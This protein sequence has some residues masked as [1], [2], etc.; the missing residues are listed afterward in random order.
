MKIEE[1]EFCPRI[2][3]NFHEEDLRLF[4]YFAISLSSY[5]AI[6]LSSLAFG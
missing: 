6:Q 1:E 4:C 3:T 2:D 5:P